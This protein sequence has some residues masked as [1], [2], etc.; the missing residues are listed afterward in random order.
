[1]VKKLTAVLICS[2]VI[3]SLSACGD[4]QSESSPKYSRDD[5]LGE[6]Y[7]GEI[8]GSFYFGEDNNLSLR[9][10]VTDMMYIDENNIAHIAGSD[11]DFSDSC[12][13]DGRTYSFEVNGV[14]MLTMSREESS[15]SAFGEYTLQSGILY[16]ELSSVYG[17]LNDR[18]SII[19]DK[20]TLNAQIRMCEFSVKN[21]I[22]TFS[23]NDLSFFGADEGTASIF[24]FAVQSDV[25]TLVGTSNTLVF[26][27]VK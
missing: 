16:D 18:Y 25:L 26:A 7:S 10:D 24:N 19:A 12:D 15:E 6:W 14:D 1:M 27:K 11:E 9:V 2:A 3:S 21:N 4:S 5:I 22:I 17:D 23:G 20:D 8:G 13:F